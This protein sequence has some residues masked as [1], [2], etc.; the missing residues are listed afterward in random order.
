MRRFLVA[1][2]LVIGLL[3]ALAA[4]ATVTDSRGE[5][6]FEEVPR[7]VV[8]LSWSLAEQMLELGVEPVAIA[9]PEGYRTWVARPPL[10]EG[11]A[12]VG[13]RQEPNLE[14]IAELAPDLILASDDQLSFVPALE[15]IAPLLHFRTFSAKHDNAEAARRTFRELARLF[16]R[17]EIAERRL[18]ELDAHLA[19]LRDRITEHYGDAPPPVAVIRLVDEGRVVIY[20]DNAMS[21]FALEALGLSNAF[22]LPPSQWGIAFRRI[23][24][25]ARIP[26]NALVLNIGPFPQGEALFAKPLWQALPFVR[27]G[28]FRPLPPVW[29]YGGINS[30]GYLA[31]EIA[32]AL[33]APGTE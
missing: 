21:S 14:R 26:A 12:G 18:A 3:P 30:I 25:L 17:E 8:A 4:G 2:F 32:A 23:E 22:D 10:P 24:D 13:L 19:G 27:A 6:E 1:F 28:R 5:H 33:P 11:V 20:G 31:E 9:D 29:T 15:Q 7:R 16:G